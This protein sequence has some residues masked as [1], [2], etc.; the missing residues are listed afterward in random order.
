MV[1]G[2]TIGDG[3]VNTETDQLTAI[4][5]RPDHDGVAT[6]VEVL[7]P[8]EGFEDADMGEG[9][10]RVLVIDVHLGVVVYFAPAFARQ[11]YAIAVLDLEGTPCPLP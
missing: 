2:G 4:V 8:S 10:V 9:V 5:F 7:G 1:L 6:H 11:Q 3:S